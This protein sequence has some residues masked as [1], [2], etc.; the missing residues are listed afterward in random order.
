MSQNYS[1]EFFSV[2]FP[3]THVAHVE[4]DRAQ[5]LNAFYEP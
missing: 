2:T 4:I 3:E 1:L 5:K